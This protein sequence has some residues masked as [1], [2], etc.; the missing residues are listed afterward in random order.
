[1]DQMCPKCFGVGWVCEMHP[2]RP[3]NEDLGCMCGLG[4]PCEC[5]AVNEDDARFLDEEITRH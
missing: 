4:L 3:W 1:M 5:N 2:D